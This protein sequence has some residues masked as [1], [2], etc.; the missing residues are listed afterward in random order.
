MEEA[1]RQAAF[2]SEKPPLGWIRCEKCN[3]G[4]V[5]PSDKEKLCEHI[6]ELFT[7]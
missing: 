6:R 7:K 1:Y 4:Y 2:G 3:R 5:I